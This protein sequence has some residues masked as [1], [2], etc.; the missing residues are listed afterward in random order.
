LISPSTILA[1]KGV[2]M[3]EADSAE[4]PEDYPLIK[5]CIDKDRIGTGI[6]MENLKGII[7]SD[8]NQCLA[9]CGPFDPIIYNYPELTADLTTVFMEYTGNKI[10]LGAASKRIR[11][12]LPGPI[13]VQQMDAYLDASFCTYKGVPELINWC[14]GNK[15]LFMINTTGLTG[16]FQRVFAKKLLPRVPVLSANG[17]V[18]YPFQATDPPLMY[19]LEE[20]QDKGKNTACALESFGISEKRMVIIGDSGGDGPHF[21]W[22]KQNKAY[23]IGSMAKQSL[24]NYCE[25]NKIGIDLFFGPTY[26]SGR[27]RSDDEEMMVDFMESIPV[28]ERIFA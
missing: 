7:S 26:T 28:F 13:S 4:C 23:L 27:Q 19:D 20:I 24:T 6:Q 21:E 17:M 22:G 3:S 8:W 15:I 10:S 25:K 2:I 5:S 14:T 9:P 16:Y 18:R 12:L 1:A 11:Q